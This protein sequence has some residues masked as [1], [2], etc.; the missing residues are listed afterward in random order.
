MINFFRVVKGKGLGFRFKDWLD[1]KS[2][3]QFLAYSDGS[4]TSYQLVKIYAL[5]A[6]TEVRKITKPVRKSVE[7]YIGDKKT[8]LYSLNYDTGALTFPKPPKKGIKIEV[9]F[10]FDVP[11]RFNTDQ[12]SASIENHG[13]HSFDNIELIEIYT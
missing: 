11:V 6:N 2:E 12:I 7:V 8:Q 3:R 5:G 1:Y 10:E 9:T 13:V 4:I